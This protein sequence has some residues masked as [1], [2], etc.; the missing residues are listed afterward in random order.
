[1]T[2]YGDTSYIFHIFHSIGKLSI[3]IFYADSSSSY[4]SK[5]CIST[6]WSKQ[7]LFAAIGIIKSKLKEDIFFGLNIE[8]CKTLM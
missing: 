4:R 1:M 6:E 3:Y 8:N 7:Y 5:I 2:S